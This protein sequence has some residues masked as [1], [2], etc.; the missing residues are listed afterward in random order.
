MFEDDEVAKEFEESD[1]M[2]N[3]HKHLVQTDNLHEALGHNTGD[4]DPSPPPRP[5]PSIFFG[6]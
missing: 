3:A 2:D 1:M 6:L 5:H 4:R